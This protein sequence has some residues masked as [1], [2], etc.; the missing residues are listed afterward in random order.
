[1]ANP[2]CRYIN[3]VKPDEEQQCTLWI[4]AK[5]AS[6]TTA[7]LGGPLTSSS[8]A[9]APRGTPRPATRSPRGPL[10]V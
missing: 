8:T 2:R 1:V 6:R 4:A 9:R 5:C 7:G 3:W 10:S